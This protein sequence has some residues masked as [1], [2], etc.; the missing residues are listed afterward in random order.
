MRPQFV[1]LAGLLFLAL[2]FFAARAGALSARPSVP[3]VSAADA[4]RTVYYRD[5]GHQ[6]DMQATEAVQRDVYQCQVRNGVW[7]YT[8]RS[9]D[10]R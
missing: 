2:V 7:N 9:C 6:L 10:S 4:T 3:Q 8:L 1:V 5:L